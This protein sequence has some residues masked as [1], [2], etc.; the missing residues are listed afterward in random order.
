[1]VLEVPI[2]MRTDTQVSPQTTPV[3]DSLPNAPVPRQIAVNLFPVSAGL[4][5]V[6]LLGGTMNPAWTDLEPF[7]HM[8]EKDPPDPPTSTPSDLV[9]L[10]LRPKPNRR[11]L[12]EQMSEH[13]GYS[14]EDVQEILNPV[15]VPEPEDLPRLRTR[16]ALKGTLVQRQSTLGKVATSSK[17][18]RKGR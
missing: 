6:G 13:E 2:H 5:T 11:K 9:D 7:G 1:M 3:K 18:L 8:Q 17:K 10:T 14:G 12:L 15:P 4:V 16:S